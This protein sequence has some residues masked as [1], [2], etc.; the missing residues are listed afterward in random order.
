MCENHFCQN[1]ATCHDDDIG[2]G[3]T[4]DCPPGFDGVLCE[5]DK[6]ECGSSPC[7]H[8]TCLDHVDGFSCHCTPG[9]VGVRCQND[10]DECA[11]T[12]C[13]HG[14]CVDLVNGFECVCTVRNFVMSDWV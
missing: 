12:P 2:P 10:T 1:N 8:G 9:Y 4:C 7:I 6:D 13:E 14:D 3:Y 5:T 11:S